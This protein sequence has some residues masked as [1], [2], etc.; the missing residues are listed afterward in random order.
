[1]DYLSSVMEK[2]D[3]DPKVRNMKP[4]RMRDVSGQAETFVRLSARPLGVR[5]SHRPVG[6]EGDDWGGICRPLGGT[7]ADEYPH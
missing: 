5:R 7:C 1:M 4:L 3:N 6:C 2:D